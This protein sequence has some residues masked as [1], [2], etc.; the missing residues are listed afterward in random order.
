MYYPTVF[1]AI[2]A[3]NKQYVLPLFLSCLLDLDYDKSSICLYMRSNNNT[4]NTVGMLEDF[5]LKNGS[6]Y[7]EIIT[8]FSDVP[9]KVEAYGEHE[10]NSVRFGVLA[11]IRQTSMDLSH[12]KGYSYYFVIDCDNFITSQTLKYLINANVDVVGPLLHNLDEVG[13]MYSNYHHCADVNGYFRHCEHYNGVFRRAAEYT[14]VIPVD[15]IHCTY[16]IKRDVIP[17]LSYSDGSSDYEYVIFSRSCRHNNIQQ[18]IDNR[19]NYGVL[20]FQGEKFASL[21]PTFSSRLTELTLEI[22]DI[23][24]DLIESTSSDISS[25]E[26]RNSWIWILF[27]IIIILLILLIMWFIIRSLY[28]KR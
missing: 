3:K 1:I 20:T 7:K 28:L 4:D 13:N 18:Y 14:G 10:W 23:S 25:H 16:L 22:P 19:Y 8:D 2:L 17:L 9:E 27:G 21:E 6:K 11:R 26:H 15:V 12:S 24:L 5:V